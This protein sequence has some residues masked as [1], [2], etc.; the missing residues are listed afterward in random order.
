MLCWA[1]LERKAQGKLS[2][3]YPAFLKIWIFC[4]SGSFVCVNF[5]SKKYFMTM[6]FPLINEV[7]RCPLQ[8]CIPSKCTNPSPLSQPWGWSRGSGSLIFNP[9]GCASVQIFCPWFCILGKESLQDSL[10]SYNNSVYSKVVIK[11]SI[12]CLFSLLNYPNVALP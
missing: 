7:F 11:L 5:D 9:D 8:F 6:L 12:S 4:S 10:P 1:I 2:N 3:S